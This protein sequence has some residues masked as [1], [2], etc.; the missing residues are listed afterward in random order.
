MPQFISE[1]QDLS[2]EVDC[3]F[4]EFEFLFQTGST[5][6][7]STIQTFVFFTPPVCDS[8]FDEGYQR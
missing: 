3:L 5:R 7:D 1:K 6:C 4:L 2:L 8:L